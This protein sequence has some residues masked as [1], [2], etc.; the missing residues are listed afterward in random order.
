M[1]KHF[2]VLLL[3][4]CL[5]LCCTLA[6]AAEG[7]K[8]EVSTFDEFKAALNDNSISEIQ[9]KPISLLLRT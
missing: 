5:C 9:L 2:A 8:K 6:A 7:T 3:L 4:L 1:K